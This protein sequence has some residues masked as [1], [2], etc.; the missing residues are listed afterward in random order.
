MTNFLYFNYICIFI[1]PNYIHAFSFHSYKILKLLNDRIT[2]LN[3]NTL[4]INNFYFIF[5]YFLN[6]KNKIKKQLLIIIYS[7]GLIGLFFTTKASYELSYIKNIKITHNDP[8]YLNIFFYSASIFI[9][10]KTHFNS[11]KKIIQK[12]AKYT[13]GIYLV[14]PFV[15]DNIIKKLKLFYSDFNFLLLIP[16]LNIFIFLISLVIC[17]ILNSIPIIGKLLI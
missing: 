13:F 17:F 2:E 4:S 5:G 9:L 7:V 8:R 16:A 11:N 6:T 14:H 3:I 1:I 12:L 10:F 15:I